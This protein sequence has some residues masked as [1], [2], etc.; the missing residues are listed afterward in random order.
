[1]KGS[2]TKNKNL[3]RHVREKH[4][5]KKRTDNEK[6]KKDVTDKARK[7][8]ILAGLYS[9]TFGDPVE[10]IP[11][12][13]FKS[14]VDYFAVAMKGSFTMNKSL[15]RHV[16]TGHQ[17]MKRTD[18]EK[19]KRD[20]TDKVRKQGHLAC[21]DIRT[22]EVPVESVTQA[23]FKPPAEYVMMT[24]KGSFTK[25]KSLLRHV[26]TGHQGMKRTDNEKRKKDQESTDKARKQGILACG[27]WAA[28][29]DV[30]G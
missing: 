26:R 10:S 23:V 1:M 7:Q 19:R 29:E 21:T 8:G 3:L 9:E 28:C 18:N 14:P 22:C 20:V 2:F 15:L 4:Q 11:Q 13:V 12:A 25:N 16:R 6:R 27:S 5:G 30:I 24:M 17:G